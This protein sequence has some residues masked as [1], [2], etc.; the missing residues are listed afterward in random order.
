MDQQAEP[1]VVPRNLWAIG[2]T[3]TVINSLYLHLG[4]VDTSKVEG[5][6]VVNGGIAGAEVNR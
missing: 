1:Q 5:A 4:R 2:H 3:V 6:G